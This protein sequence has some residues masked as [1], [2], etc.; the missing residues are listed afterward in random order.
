MT[1]KAAI[2]IF[3]IAHFSIGIFLGQWF[4]PWQV[5][6]MSI[7]FELIETPMKKAFPE[8]FPHPGYDSIQNSAMDVI[9]M[10]MGAAVSRS[11]M[12]REGIL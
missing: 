10:I 5:G 3:T 6:V 1:N 11:N 4:K 2:D 7:T 8:A 9:S 12:K